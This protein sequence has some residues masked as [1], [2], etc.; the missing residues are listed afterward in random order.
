MCNAAH[1]LSQISNDPQEMLSAK[2]Q[3][4]FFFAW[5]GNEKAYKSYKNLHFYFEK[6]YLSESSWHFESYMYSR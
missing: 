5:R 1:A 6:S 3:M 4:V 2:L